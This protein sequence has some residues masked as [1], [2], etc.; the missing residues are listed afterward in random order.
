MDNEQNATPWLDLGPHTFRLEPQTDTF[1]FCAG[2]DFTLDTTRVL[3][4]ELRRFSE[5]RERLFVLADASGMGQ[6][7]GEARR[8]LA[9]LLKDLPIVATVVFG[10]SF[11]QRV[12]ATLA[13]KTNN[14][15]R[16]AGRYETRFFKTEA[17]ARAWLE[18]K[19][20][21]ALASGALP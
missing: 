14:L 15:I 8:L 6:L 7:S 18:K 12:L 2:G 3:V 10:A 19:R 21:R 17:E 11:A 5:T 20:H 13:D 16:R 4:A 9:E 1:I